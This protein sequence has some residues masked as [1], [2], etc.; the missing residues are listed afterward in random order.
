MQGPRLDPRRCPQPP[1][2]D[3]HP[4][5][6]VH[7]SGSRSGA[8]ELDLPGGRS[9]RPVSGLRRE[10]RSFRVGR[11]HRTGRLLGAHEARVPSRAAGRPVSQG[12]GLCRACR[13]PRPAMAPPAL[14][15]HDFPPVRPR[16]CV[17]RSWEGRPHRQW[18]LAPFLPPATSGSLLSIPGARRSTRLELVLFLLGSSIF[19]FKKW[20]RKLDP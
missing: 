3:D 2:R 17:P 14:R 12:R 5:T 4:E 19:S 18:L 13:P 16:V 11:W 7:S 1:S 9:P 8:K 10:I 20:K 15:P 6:T